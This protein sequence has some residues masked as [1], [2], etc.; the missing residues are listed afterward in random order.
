MSQI[1]EQEHPFS[2]KKAPIKVIDRRTILSEIDQTTDLQLKTT[3]I[4]LDA[5]ASEPLILGVLLSERD[6]IVGGYYVHYFETRQKGQDA[7][8]R[9][10]EASYAFDRLMEPITQDIGL[11]A[12]FVALSL[13]QKSDPENFAINFLKRIA[14]EEKDLKPLGIVMFKD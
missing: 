11:P 9:T 10:L 8:G 4:A 12:E 13:E 3:L 7:I 1:K 5:L 14:K 6:D 2:S